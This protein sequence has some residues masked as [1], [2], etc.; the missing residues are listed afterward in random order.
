MFILLTPLYDRGGGHPI[1]ARESVLV[2]EVLE[3]GMIRLSL[4]VFLLR[5]VVLFPLAFPWAFLRV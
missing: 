4:I 5:D 3:S 2:L 1:K